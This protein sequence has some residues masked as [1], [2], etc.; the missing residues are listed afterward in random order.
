MHECSSTRG[1][2]RVQPRVRTRLGWEMGPGHVGHCVAPC[3]TRV[4][5]RVEGLLVVVQELVGLGVACMGVP[6]SLL[7]LLVH[8]CCSCRSVGVMWGD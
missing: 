7:L 8:S 4:V 6:H 1:Q 3:C 5:A 2:V